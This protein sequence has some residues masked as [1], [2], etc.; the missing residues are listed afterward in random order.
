MVYNNNMDVKICKFVIKFVIRML[1][2]KYFDKNIARYSYAA[3]TR[4]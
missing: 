3:L 2:F 1:S 4:H